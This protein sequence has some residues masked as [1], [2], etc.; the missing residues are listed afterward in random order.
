MRRVHSSPRIPRLLSALAALSIAVPTTG[1][2]AMARA[3]RSA[4]FAHPF[5]G[6]VAEASRRFGVPAAWI[7][8]VMRVESAGV[9][10]AISSAGAMGLM[11]IMPAT[12]SGLC[13][14]YGLG[15]DPYDPRDNIMAGAAYLR[16]MHDRYR[17]PT[18]MLAAYNAGPGRYDDYRL[19]GR[20]LPVETVAYV[21][22]LAPIVVG[23]AEDAAAVA[24]PPDSFSWRGAGLFVRTAIVSEPTTDL[25]RTSGTNDAIATEPR[26]RE[27]QREGLF[28]SRASA[29][30]PQ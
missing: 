20:P 10:G 8:A 21:A 26:H 16:E 3:A 6:H 12:W 1:D 11:Q 13:A 15:A 27:P 29:G 22:R 30:Q 28:V 24:P 2:I 19:R 7:W 17:D 9:V 5:A 23:R 4:S 14:R 18:A 25:P